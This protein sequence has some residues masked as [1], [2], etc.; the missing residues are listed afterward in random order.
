MNLQL[1]DL[2]VTE[3]RRG[4]DAHERVSVRRAGREEA[5]DMDSLVQ[6]QAVVQGNAGLVGLVALD[7][8][9]RVWYGDL[10]TAPA[11]ARYSVKWTKIE[12]RV[13]GPATRKA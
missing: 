3:I 6:I 5:N 4:G 8:E 10:S 1:G 12:E 9:G 11:P 13:E 2:G 7:K